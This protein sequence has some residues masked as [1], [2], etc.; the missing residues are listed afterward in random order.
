MN[1]A[2]V[3]SLYDW[4]Q[5][6]LSMSH[7]Q[8]VMTQLTQWRS[9]L[10]TSITEMLL[11]PKFNNSSLS[12]TGDKEICHVIMSCHHYPLRRSTQWKPFNNVYLL[13]KFDVSSF[14]MTED[15]QIFKMVIL[16]DFE[17]FKVDIY[18]TNFGQVKINPIW[19]ILLTL[20]RSHL[21]Y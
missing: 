19:S 7:D 10:S 21:F 9:P 17:Q 13:S 6:D 20:D 18:F 15:I 16:L 1:V 2:P 14:S 8:K 3:A 11:L 4:R 5:K 12:V